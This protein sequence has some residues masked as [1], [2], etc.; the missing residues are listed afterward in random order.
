MHKER[1]PFK[2]LSVARVFLT[3]AAGV[4]PLGPSAGGR[5]TTPKE[6]MWRLFIANP[7]LSRLMAEESAP[8]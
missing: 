1:E 8:N 3:A 4:R 7:S 2:A 5:Q 6:A